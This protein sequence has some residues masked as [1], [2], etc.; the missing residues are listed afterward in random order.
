M[1]TGKMFTPTPP[2]S[3]CPHCHEYIDEPDFDQHVKDCPPTCDWYKDYEEFWKPI[4]EKDGV[5]DMNQLK[6]E[7]SDY[8]F[9]MKNVPKVYMHIT[10][11]LMSKINYD[12]DTVIDQADQCESDRTSEAIKDKLESLGYLNEGES[13]EEQ[14]AMVRKSIFAFDLKDN[15]LL[16][17]KLPETATQ[18]EYGTMEKVAGE[19]LE[20]LKVKS[21]AIIVPY[22]FDI[23]SYDLKDSLRFIVNF[24]EMTTE[25]QLDVY[26]KVFK[27]ADITAVFV[28]KDVDVEDEDPTTPEYKEA[29]RKL[30]DELNKH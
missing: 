13:I 3:E 15:T 16:V 5:L 25:A 24:P 26:K 17:I 27:E 28:P 2:A 14:K 6:K 29:G 12:A 10:N 18:E 21:R 19:V 8:H 11:D 7:L 9:A 4:L 22:A 1:L 23:K 20:G 30:A